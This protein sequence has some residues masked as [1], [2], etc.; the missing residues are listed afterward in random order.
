MQSPPG[1]SQPRPGSARDGT[2]RLEAFSDGVFAIAI[3]LLALN[4]EVPELDDVSTRALANRLADNWPAYLSFSL[5]FVTLLIAWVYHHRLL[6]GARHAGTELLFANGLLLLVVSSVPFPT[7]L[8]GRYLTTDAASLVAALYAAYI[9]VLNL[10]YNILWWVVVRQKRAQGERVPVPES[11]LLSYA[12]F[13][14][15]MVAVAIA[16]LSP[17]VTLVI[18]GSLW[19]VW[20]F[21]APALS[22][23]E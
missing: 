19:V 14:I 8:L 4:L 9:G 2:G 6:E 12:G 3:T 23:E 7:A 15:Y 21:R 18:C 20:T 1:R 22:A 17:A 16:F 11:M 10:T 5:S 13:P